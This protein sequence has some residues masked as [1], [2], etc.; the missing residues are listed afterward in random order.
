MSEKLLVSRIRF[1]EFI[2]VWEQEKLGNFGILIGGSFI[3]NF[4]NNIGKYKVISIGS[5][6][7][8]NIYN[9]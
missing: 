8:D 9:D 6:L 2:N 1:K 3:E 4:F 7:E 5:F